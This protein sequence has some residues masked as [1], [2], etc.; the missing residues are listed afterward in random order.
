MIR[1][2]ANL[3]RKD[4]RKPKTTSVVDS[5]TSPTLAAALLK[6]TRSRQRC[7]V[8]MPDPP[9]RRGLGQRAQWRCCS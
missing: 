8:F 7:G 5:L 4:D 3:G 9:F 2:L 1:M 6:E